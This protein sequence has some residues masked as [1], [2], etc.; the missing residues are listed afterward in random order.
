[1]SWGLHA[2]IEHIAAFA[3]KVTMS[4]KIYELYENSKGI[5]NPS[6]GTKK[7]V[8]DFFQALLLEQINDSTTIL[9]KNL[10]T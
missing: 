1:M 7:I 10:D 8:I 2:V 9:R 4:L 5:S 3:L 6:L